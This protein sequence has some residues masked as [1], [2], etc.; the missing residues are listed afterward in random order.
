MPVSV[1]LCLLSRGDIKT[2]DGS[3]MYFN[4]HW[5]AKEQVCRER[6]WRE[7]ERD[8]K[9]KD[10]EEQREVPWVLKVFIYKPAYI[11]VY[12]FCAYL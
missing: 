7:T 5:K 2:W 12:I 10:R 8:T 3:V 11:Q 9:R 4:T 1:W 6:E